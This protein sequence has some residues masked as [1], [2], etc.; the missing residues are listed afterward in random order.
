M[1]YAPPL[2]DRRVLSARALELIASGL[3]VAVNRDAVELCPGEC[4]RYVQ[5]VETSDYDAWLIAWAPGALLEAHDHGGS[6][7]AVQV[8]DGR[9]IEAYL[10]RGDD[11]GA[12][13]TRV[14]DAGDVL[15]VPPNR[16]HEVWNPGSTVAYSVHVYSPPLTDMEFFEL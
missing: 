7:G 3:A 5:L 9:L 4:R 10:D 2:H 16:I 6:R 14:A 1:T 11:D 8:V 13:R 12:P 15:D